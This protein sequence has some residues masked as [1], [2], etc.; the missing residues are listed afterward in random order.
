[1]LV[2]VTLGTGLGVFVG[3]GTWVDVFGVFS[4]IAFGFPHALIEYMIIKII[5]VVLLNFVLLIFPLVKQR[6]LINCWP[7]K[8]VAMVK[9][10]FFQ[11]IFIC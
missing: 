5:I 9:H 4:V 6:F 7:L 1:M 10:I 11:L 2:G 8:V 3:L